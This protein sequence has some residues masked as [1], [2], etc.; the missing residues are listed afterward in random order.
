MHIQIEL[1]FFNSNLKPASQPIPPQIDQIETFFFS[2]VWSP[3]MMKIPWWLAK[4]ECWW[5]C[6]QF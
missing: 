2:R 5:C 4:I 1:L 3:G 6:G